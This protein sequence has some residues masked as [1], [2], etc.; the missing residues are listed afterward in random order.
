MK[1]SIRRKEARKALEEFA[2]AGELRKVVQRFFQPSWICS[3]R[4]MTRGIRVT[5]HIVGMYC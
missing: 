4:S 3:S 5:S 2:L 1:K